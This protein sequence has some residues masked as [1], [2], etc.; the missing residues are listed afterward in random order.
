VLIEEKELEDLIPEFHFLTTDLSREER[1]KLIL[2][3]VDKQVKKLLSAGDIEINK[4]KFNETD[5]IWLM[6]ID[7]NRKNS[8]LYEL[9]KELQND[10]LKVIKEDGFSSKKYLTQVMSDIDKLHEKLDDCPFE[11]L[12][13]L[14]FK[15]PN[16]A[17]TVYKESHALFIGKEE[18]LF[19]SGNTT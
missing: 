1:E 17:E 11:V 4:L 9:R 2:E 10:R 16:M 15:D 8:F 14:K 18:E 13:M 7:E 3:W 5:F 6:H 19:Q 12:Q